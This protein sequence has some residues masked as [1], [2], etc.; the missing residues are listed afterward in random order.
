MNYEPLQNY[1]LGIYPGTMVD[2]MPKPESKPNFI[3]KFAQKFKK[4]T[5]FE[6]LI[7]ELR[8]VCE[9]E[10]REIG[11]NLLEDFIIQD[12]DRDLET[13]EVYHHTLEHFKNQGYFYEGIRGRGRILRNRDGQRIGVRVCTGTKYLTGRVEKLFLE[14]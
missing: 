4:E 9:A 13:D 5:I 3:E 11:E 8:E 1:L 6:K 7:R 12:L 2:T 10:K 14:E